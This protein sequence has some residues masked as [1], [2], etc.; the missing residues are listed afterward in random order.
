MGLSVYFEAEGKGIAEGD[1][2]VPLAFAS[3]ALRDVKPSP[4]GLLGAL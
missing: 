3:Q 1:A 2:S 4:A